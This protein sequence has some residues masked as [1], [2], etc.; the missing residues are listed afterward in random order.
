M[1]NVVMD[2]VE[3]NCETGETIERP[4]TAEERERYEAGRLAALAEKQAREAEEARIAELKASA[5]AKL[6]S[7]Q[8]LTEE[9]VSLLVI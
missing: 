1:E 6:M 2:V 9:E 3:V 4:F 8:P 7:G 5:K